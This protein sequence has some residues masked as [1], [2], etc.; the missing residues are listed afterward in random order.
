M[1]G[2]VPGDFAQHQGGAPLDAH[3]EI[4]EIVGHPAGQGSD[5]LH[6]LGLQQLVLQFAQ[7]GDVAPHHHDTGDGAVFFPAGVVGCRYSAAPNRGYR[8][9]L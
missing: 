3:E 1:K 7:I 2:V 8:T 5:G 9:R 4:V 6:F